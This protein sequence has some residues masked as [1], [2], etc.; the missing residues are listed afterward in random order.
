[1]ANEITFKNN[2]LFIITKTFSRIGFGNFP[3]ISCMLL[4]L[5][6]LEESNL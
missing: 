3:L 5:S 1:M 4:N 6:K 2:F